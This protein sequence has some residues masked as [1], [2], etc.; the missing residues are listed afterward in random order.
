LKK[1]LSF[2]IL[3][4]IFLCI[5]SIPDK[6]RAEE[7]LKI[8]ILDFSQENTQ[9]TYARAVRNLFEVSLYKT[10]HFSI[11]ERNK[12]E[13]ILKEQGLQMSG[14]TDTS[15]AVQI[16]KILSADMIIIGSLNKLGKFTVAVKFINVGEGHIVAADSE[17][18][19]TEDN[20]QI[21]I[22]ALARKMTDGI[23]TKPAEKPVAPVAKSAKEEDKKN[24][25]EKKSDISF[26]IS[27]SGS[28][29]L[30]QSRFS[31]LVKAGYGCALSFCAG[32][33][34]IKNSLL[35]IETGYWQY[36]GKKVNVD[37]CTMIP[38]F[39]KAG[40]MF[41]IINKLYITPSIGAGISYNSMSWDKDGTT[42]GNYQFKK[43]NKIETVA[44]MEINLGY[45]ISDIFAVQI[46]AGY[47][48]I[49]EKKQLGF[50]IAS[51]GVGVRL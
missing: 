6:L 30:P 37:S 11:L 50:W 48:M 47:C 18:A 40:Y 31:D 16:G 45:N 36:P 26:I 4:I 23:L 2:S 17:S 33:I 12:I 42:D 14:C 20:L 5:T 28:F 46:G 21:A 22:D 1:R 24:I 34:F 51:A 13:M 8:A 35:G 9:Q 43:E 19:D 15:C 32:N 41:S 39:A 10:G 49:F 29:L 7:K 25:Q 3:F 44:K 38:L 27:I